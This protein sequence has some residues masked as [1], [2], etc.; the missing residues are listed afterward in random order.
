MDNQLICQPF[1]FEEEAICSP[2]DN[3]RQVIMGS[4]LYLETCVGFWGPVVQHFSSP[5]NL[6]S[7]IMLPHHCTPHGHLPIKP[8]CEGRKLYHWFTDGKPQ[9]HKD[10]SLCS[11]PCFLLSSKIWKV[12][13]HISKVVRLG[14]RASLRDQIISWSVLSLLFC[15]RHSGTAFAWHWSGHTS[16]LVCQL[17][18]AWQCVVNLNYSWSD[19][20]SIM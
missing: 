6:S 9:N 11:M 14:Y 15:F 7:Y 3:E 8:S 19:L 20:L 13:S 17:H 2:G 18:T 16:L 10:L 1:C 12:Y 5:F 4:S